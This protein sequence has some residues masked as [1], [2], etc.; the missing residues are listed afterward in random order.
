[1]NSMKFCISGTDINTLRTAHYRAMLMLPEEVSSVNHYQNS[2][3]IDSN[4]ETHS[5]D[6]LTPFFRWCKNLGDVKVEVF[7]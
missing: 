2:F 1:M 3:T 7:S 5:Q 4:I 6:I